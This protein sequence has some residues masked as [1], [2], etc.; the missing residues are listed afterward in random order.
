MEKG[1]GG[2][3]GTQNS[4]MISPVVFYIQRLVKEGHKYITIVIFLWS[5]FM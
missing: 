3:G 5:F 4:Q 2:G 1:G